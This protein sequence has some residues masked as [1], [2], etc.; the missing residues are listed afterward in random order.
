M[1][2]KEEQI[3]KLK[4]GISFDEIVI[5]CFNSNY[6]VKHVSPIVTSGWCRYYV[7]CKCMAKPPN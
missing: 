4:E 1:E 3:Q 5:G 2:H 6:R 7:K